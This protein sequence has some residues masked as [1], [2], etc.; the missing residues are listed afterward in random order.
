MPIGGAFTR[1]SS[2]HLD[3]KLPLS[4]HNTINFRLGHCRDY[5]RQQQAELTHFLPQTPFLCSKWSA[6]PCH[7][8]KNYSSI[9][10]IVRN[11]RYLARRGTLRVGVVYWRYAL[12]VA[13]LAPSPGWTFP[14]SDVSILVPSC[15][16][17]QNLST[18]PCQ[19]GVLY[20]R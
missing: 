3:Q 9:C 16:C 4:W 11:A 19:R 8:T 14:A 2:R 18:C 13:T 15:G 1:E 5:C 12:A 7:P 17:Y 10:I 20:P 6:P